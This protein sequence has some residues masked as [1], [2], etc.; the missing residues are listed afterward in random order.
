[1]RND[2]IVGIV[3]SFVG[4]QFSE[5]CEIIVINIK[6]YHRIFTDAGHKSIIHYLFVRA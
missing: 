5:Q 2:Y 1:M 4:K 3:I 6:I